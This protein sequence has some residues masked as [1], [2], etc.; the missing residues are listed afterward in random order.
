MSSDPL[1]SVAVPAYNHGRFIRDCLT[2]VR[3]QT[4]ENLELVVIDDGSQDDTAQ[5]V[6]RFLRDHEA[7]FSR[8][9]FRSRPNRGVSA[10]SNECIRLCRGEWVHLLGSDDLLR[11]DKV[12]VQWRMFR[13]WGDPDLALIYGDAD[14]IDADGRIIERP[15]GIRPPPGPNRQGYLELFLANRIPNPTVALRRDAFERIGGFDES[16]FLEDWD[17]WLRLSAR[18]PIARVPQ[19][20]ASYRY[21]PGNTHRRQAEMLDAMLTSFGKFLRDEGERIPPGLLRKNWRKNLHRL[22][23]WARRS[24]PACLP[25]LA[26]SEARATLTLPAPDD[27]FRYAARIHRRL[28]SDREDRP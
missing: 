10:T 27:Y 4:Y 14:S 19:V 26:L 20:L 25:A 1:I 21:H 18:Y 6:E 7:R 17:C 24:D 12:A 8:T 15:P 3:N 9:V 23:R 13:E 2:S 22:Y 28:E 5:E 11:E 16:L